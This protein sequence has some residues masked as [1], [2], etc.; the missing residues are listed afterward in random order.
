VDT[1]AGTQDALVTRDG[2]IM[3]LTL[4]RP[5]TR[6]AMTWAMYERLLQV[7]EEVDA[8]DSVRVLILRGAGGK[9]FVAGTDISQ[10]KVFETAE[11][12]LAYERDGAA[13]SARLE[14]VRKPVIAQIQGF[15]VG[16]GFNITACC[17]LRI[18]T[19]D[20]KFGAPIA[21]TL[22]NCLSMET[23]ARFVDLLGTS[24]VKD[25]IFRA[26]F[27]TAEEA[28]A[29]GFVHEIVPPEEIDARV[30]AIALEIADHAPITIQVTNEALR[31][32]R[33]HRGLPDGDDLIARTYTSADFREG[34]AAFVEKRKPRW[35]GK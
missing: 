32:L 16:G 17:D 30:K 28:L 6:N 26:R 29:A 13:R 20:A 12:G 2:A 14:R 8:D 27:F 33:D 7:C 22:G 24:R 1:P 35:T 5:Q 34:A 25:V 11:D 15:A 21:R 10:F 19:P 18:A 3:T 9:A 4:N 23:Y 31:R